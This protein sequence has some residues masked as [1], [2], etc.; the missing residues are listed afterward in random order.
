LINRILYKYQIYV[1]GDQENCEKV[2]KYFNDISICY[3]SQFESNEEKLVAVIGSKLCLNINGSIPTTNLNV[4]STAKKL[5]IPFLSWT[6][7]DPENF[8]ELI[9]KIKEYKIEINRNPN[10]VESTNDILVGEEMKNINFSNERLVYLRGDAFYEMMI[11]KDFQTPT[12]KPTTSRITHSEESK[13][14]EISNNRTTGTPKFQIK[15]S[16]IKS[17]EFTRLCVNCSNN[18]SMRPYYS[19]NNPFKPD[20][21]TK[22]L[23][24]DGYIYFIFFF[25]MSREYI[26]LYK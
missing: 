3:S 23:I 7:Q 15:E 6:F 22:I 12:I 1:N 21:K 24:D 16:G 9:E 25:F 19:F 26:T 13:T 5:K 17:N 8:E 2:Q 4:E 14:S 11:N 20:Y 10:T 18:E